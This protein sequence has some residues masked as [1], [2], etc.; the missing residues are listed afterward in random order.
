MTAALRMP[1]PSRFATRDRRWPFWA[2][3]WSA[4]VAAE[5][6]AL[7][8]VLFQ[9]HP[10]EGLDILF[11]VTG[12]SFLACGLVAWHRRPDSRAGLL[13]TLTGFALFIVPI[14]SQFGTAG[15]Q[16]FAYLFSDLWTITFVALLLTFAT[17]GRMRSGTDAAL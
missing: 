12:G 8:P 14:G 5:F 17:G 3:L 6:G 2:V 11:R 9:D 10:I 7:V 4:A 13:M 15:P 16:T 1:S